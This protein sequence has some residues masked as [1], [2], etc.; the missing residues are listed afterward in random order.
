MSDTGN[1]TIAVTVWN[2]SGGLWFSSDWNG[3]TTLQQVLA[4]GSLSVH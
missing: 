3:T 2:K 1:E 4:G